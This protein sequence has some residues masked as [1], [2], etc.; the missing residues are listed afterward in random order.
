M[1]SANFAAM[2]LYYIVIGDTSSQLWA[3]FFI[4]DAVGR[5]YEDIKLDLAQEAWWIQV[6]THRTSMII[7]VGCISLI[8][9]FKQ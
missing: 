8:F 5:K 3:Q 1:L 4:K 9:I 7:L 2:V 6:V